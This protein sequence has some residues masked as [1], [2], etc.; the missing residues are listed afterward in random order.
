MKESTLGLKAAFESVCNKIE[1]LL[2]GML[3]SPA[4]PPS[5]PMGEALR[6][7]NDR[8]YIVEYQRLQKN[9]TG[10]L[11]EFDKMGNNEDAPSKLES[12]QK[13]ISEAVKKVQA[14]VEEFV[15]QYAE[16][17]LEKP[18]A[19]NYLK[20]V[21][22]L[23]EKYLIQGKSI[24]KEYRKE[25]ARVIK[26]NYNKMSGSSKWPIDNFISLK[27]KVAELSKT[28]EREFKNNDQT[29]CKPREL[30]TELSLDEKSAAF[31]KEFIETH[32]RLFS[33]TFEEY[34]NFLIIKACQEVAANAQAVRLF[35]MPRDSHEFFPRN[36]G[37]GGN[38][39]STLVESLEHL[40]ILL[41]I[42][43]P[44]KLHEYLKL[45]SIDACQICKNIFPAD[46]AE[47]KFVDLKAKTIDLKAPKKLL[48][49]SIQAAFNQ[50][51]TAEKEAM[52]A[53]TTISKKK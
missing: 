18:Y 27:E 49:D 53:A 40:C 48:Q 50:V 46:L 32:N 19:A 11:I 2:R 41:N 7:L 22:R 14:K 43:I 44:L 1:Y 45:G 37:G 25:E 23:A 28:I 10:W 33:G 52:K 42:P 17:Q 30:Q 9:I 24:S 29:Q 31:H 39:K 51:F 3:P 20:K 4:F 12:L 34:N 36:S 13:T 38:M 5:K 47:W 6:A 15:K 21:E 35:D 26:E 16:E 8:T